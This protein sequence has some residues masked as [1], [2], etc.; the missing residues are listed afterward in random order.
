MILLLLGLAYAAV[1]GRIGGIPC[2]FHLLTGLQCPGCGVTRMC[3]HLLRGNMRD[4]FYDNGAV[5]CMLPLGLL[6]LLRR[7]Y[8][9][10][11]TGDRRLTPGENRLCVGMAVVLI[12]FG[13][14]R[15][16]PW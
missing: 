9:Y 3:L 14:A 13:V 11:K 6:L 10:V 7:S 4:A 5:L 15:N 2:L 1:A 16:I 8:A 12:L